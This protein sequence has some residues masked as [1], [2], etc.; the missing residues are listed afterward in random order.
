[1]VTWMIDPDM[2]LEGWVTLVLKNIF[3]QINSVV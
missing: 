2:D 3:D 1:M